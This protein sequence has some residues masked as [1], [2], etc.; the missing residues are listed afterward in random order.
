MKMSN[1]FVIHG[2]N[3]KGDSELVGIFNSLEIANVYYQMVLLQN[4]TQKHFMRLY[5]TEAKQ[6]EADEK[7]ELRQ[8]F[9]ELEKTKWI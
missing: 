1:L 8:E 7:T 9:I 3:K 5:L 4:D 6:Y 2:V